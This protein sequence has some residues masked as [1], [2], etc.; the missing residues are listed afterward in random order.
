MLGRALMFYGLIKFVRF[1]FGREEDGGDVL[2]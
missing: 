1:V 2:W